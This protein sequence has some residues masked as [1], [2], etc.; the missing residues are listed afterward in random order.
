MIVQS[1]FGYTLRLIRDN[2]A[3][4]TS[5]GINVWAMRLAAFI[6]AGAFG[7]IGGVVM[8]LFVSGA[9]PDFAYWT[10]SGEA[11]FMIM[12]GGTTLFLGPVAGAV[13]LLLLNDVV[14]KLTEHYGLVLG[15]II[16]LFALGL[17]KGLPTIWPSCGASA[18]Q[19]QGQSPLRSDPVR[20]AIQQ[21]ERRM[22]LRQVNAADRELE[23]VLRRRR[24]HQRRQ[25]ALHARVAHRRHR[26]KWCRQDDVLST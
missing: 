16:L 19:H 23:Q 15:L 4:A 21:T 2:P 12:L 8:S 5:L 25:L 22:T 1:P 10:I 26:A 14:T 11:I 17:R 3:R 6:I 13:M 7:S 9:F 20:R 18:A 24:R